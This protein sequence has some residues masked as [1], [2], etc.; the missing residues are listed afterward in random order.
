MALTISVVTRAAPS[1]FTMRRKGWLVIPAMGAI[2][3]QLSKVRE[4]IWSIDVLKF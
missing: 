4:P 2:T 1:F 3:S